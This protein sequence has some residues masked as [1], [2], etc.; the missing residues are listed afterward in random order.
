MN[1]VYIVDYLR[2]AFSRSRPKEPERDV[3]NSIRM[4][5][6]LSMLIKQLVKRTKINPLD[7][8]DVITGCAFQAGENWLYGGRHPVLLAGLPFE[9]PGMSIDRACSSSMMSISTGTMEIMTGNSDIVLAGGMEHMTH[10]PIGD[11]PFIIPN[12]KLLTMPEYAKYR[13]GIGYNMG[14][15]AEQLSEESGIKKDDMDKFSLESHTLATKALNSG[16]INKEIMPIE[17]EFNGQKLIVDKDQSIRA[18]TTLEQIKNLPPAF[19]SGGVI[20][21]GNSSPLNAGASLVML[22]SENAIKKYGL[23]PL[24]KIRSM[25][26]AGVDPAVM[27]KGPVPATKKALERAGLKVEDIDYWEINEAF[28]VVVLYA[29]REL[30]I[31]RSKVNIHGGA[32]S[33]GHPLG[34]TGSRLIGTLSRIL[35]DEKK[36]TGVATLC[37][38]GGQGFSVVIERV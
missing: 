5:E 35:N 37:V 38:G 26:W 36:N 29:M 12:Y 11:N 3:F 15:T 17:V 24:A 23:K 33:I 6:A 4:D 22:A 2:T 27:G 9:V 19:K 8:G 31:E 28:A 7:I 25:A 18:D 16:W 30:G 1:N 32:I 14:L 13:M 10:L 20:T 34:A 21:V